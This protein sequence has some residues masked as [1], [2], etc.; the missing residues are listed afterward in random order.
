M[1]PSHTRLASGRY[2]I[3]CTIPVNSRPGTSSSRQAVA[4]TARTT[5]S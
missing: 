5:A 4:P 2:S 1:S 3:A